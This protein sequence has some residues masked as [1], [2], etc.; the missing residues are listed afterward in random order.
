MV[1]KLFI[2]A[3]SIFI[4]VPSAYQLANAERGVTDTMGTTD[5]SCCAMVCSGKG[6]RLVF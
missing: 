5:R 4:F 1:K 6:N 2:L 3:L